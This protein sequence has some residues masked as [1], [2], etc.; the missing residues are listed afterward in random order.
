MKREYIGRCDMCS[1]NLYDTDDTVSIITGFVG[2][3]ICRNCCVVN[4]GGKKYDIADLVNEIEEGMK[5]NGSV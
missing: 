4:H 3:T 2:M 5:H 1:A